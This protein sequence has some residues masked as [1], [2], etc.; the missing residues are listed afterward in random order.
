M[1]HERA[2]VAARV[3]HQ[4]DLQVVPAQ[5]F[6]HRQ[7]VLEE[8]EVVRVLPPAGHL[9]GAFVGPLGVAPHSPDDPFREEHPDLLVVL[10]LGMLLERL[11]GRCASLGMLG[12][13]E[14]EPETAPQ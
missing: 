12:R 13:V 10:E 2:E 1:R 8:L 7:R 11:D 6:Q 4:P 9:D 5:L 3:R 14:L